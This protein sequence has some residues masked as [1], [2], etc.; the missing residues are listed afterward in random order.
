MCIS[1][2]RNVVFLHVKTSDNWRPERNIAGHRDT[3]KTGTVPGKIG[4]NGIMISVLTREKLGTALPCRQHSITGAGAENFTAQL[5]INA[6]WILM[7]YIPCSMARVRVPSRTGYKGR[8]A[9]QSYSCTP[10]LT[11]TTD[12]CEG[13][14]PRSGLCTP[15]QETRHPLY[16]GLGGHQGRSGR[17]RKIS[18]PPGFDPLT[19]EP[20]ASCYTDWDIPALS[21]YIIHFLL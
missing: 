6:S 4:T 20:V 10:S 11:S 7:L 12:V 15:L 8:Q 19:V 5:L 2:V 1:I 18:P 14:N 13:S 16:R 3:H 9:E 17:V 21:R